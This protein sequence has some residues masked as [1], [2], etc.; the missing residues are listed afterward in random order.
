MKSVVEFNNYSI[1]KLEFKKNNTFTRAEKKTAIDIEVART[2]QVN[3]DN[4]TVTLQVLI[5]ND[6]EKK[7]YPFQMQLEVAGDFVITETTDEQ[8][9]ILAKENCVAILFPYIRSL[10]STITSNANV[11]P[12]IIPPINVLSLIDN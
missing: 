2:V 8:K 11:P 10:V 6:A 9:E 4:A 3:G 5:F 12:L 7:N 1:N